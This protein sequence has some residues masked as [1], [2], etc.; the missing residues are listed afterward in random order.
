MRV[1]LKWVDDDDDDDDWWKDEL[2]FPK[3]NFSLV[4]SFAKDALLM[5][6]E[7]ER[8]KCRRA[9]GHFRLLNCLFRLW[10]L[11]IRPDSRQKTRVSEFDALVV[12]KNSAGKIFPLEIDRL[13]KH[14]IAETD[15]SIE[16]FRSKRFVRETVSEQNVFDKVGD[17]RSLGDRRSRHWW[18]FVC[19]SSTL[20]VNFHLAIRVA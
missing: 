1:Y 19:F 12:G 11:R 6:P 17:F 2:V 4:R 10:R 18:G 14:R 3:S 5:A 8:T 9:S 20:K 15:V 7:E 13:F 16:D